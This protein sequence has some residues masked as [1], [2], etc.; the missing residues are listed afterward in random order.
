MAISKL[1]SGIAQ[2][3]DIVGPSGW[4]G[5]E[6]SKRYFE[7]S[8]G[9]YTG[10]AQLILKPDTTTIVAKIVNAC[11]DFGIGIIPFGGGTGG[12]AGHLNLA[13]APA[14]TLSLERMN[15]IRRIDPKSNVIVVEAGALLANVQQAANTAGRHI[16]LRLASEGSCTIGG[17]LSTNAGGVNVLRYGSARDQCLGI[18]AVMPDGKIL[19]DL[20]T[21]RKNNTGYDLRHLLIGSEGTLGVITAAALTLSPCTDENLTALCAVPSPDIAVDLLQALTAQCGT[22]VTAFEL[23]SG[24]GLSLA[25]RHFPHLRPPFETDHNW[26]VLLQVDGAAQACKMVEGWLE[27]A[28]E[29]SAIQDA[30]LATSQKQANTL[31]ELRECAYE[32]N[33]REGAF[34]TSDTAVPLGKIGDFIDAVSTS[35]T[36]ACPGFRVNFY[37]HIGDGNI[38][39][40][41]FPPDGQKSSSEDPAL[42]ALAADLNDSI[43]EISVQLGGT[44]SA[45]HGIGRSRIADME[46]YADDTNRHIQKAIKQ[47]MDPTGIMNPGAFFRM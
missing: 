33:R 30:V 10:R 28:L 6:Q 1:E 19:N 8:R 18:E 22:V 14:V 43:N 2:L 42:R 39:V 16:G 3:K 23:L 40:N 5:P 20:N 35:I 47:T 13:E 26:Y 46:R 45:E 25:S 24:L 27:E 44:F 12:A 9:I 31:W 41:V 11:R 21:V 29:R 34:V 7:D 4:L 17:N 36:K 15:A 37:G 38:H 32:Y